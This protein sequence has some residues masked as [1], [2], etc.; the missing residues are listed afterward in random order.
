[1]FIETLSAIT[2]CI[3]FATAYRLAATE[4]RPVR[5]SD[6]VALAMRGLYFSPQGILPVLK[7]LQ[8]PEKID[9]NELQAAIARFRDGQQDVERQLRHLNW[10]NLRQDLGLGIATMER[11]ERLG[12]EKIGLRS[13]II[14]F[15][16]RYWDGERRP[17]GWKNDL[18]RLI[19]EIEDLNKSIRDLDEV[20]NPRQARLAL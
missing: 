6:D 17:R 10:D 12:L 20:V 18:G 13:A 14:D 4:G 11:L 9:D 2:A 3:E 1:M 15:V 19:D 8:A 16:Q 7:R 5:N